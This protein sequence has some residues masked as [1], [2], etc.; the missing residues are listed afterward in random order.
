MEEKKNSMGLCREC[1]SGCTCEGMYSDHWMSHTEHTVVRNILFFML[2]V[3]VFWIGL[4]LGELRAYLK[5]ETNAMYPIHNS[6]MGS[7]WD[8]NEV[9]SMM[10]RNTGP[11][12]ATQSPAPSS[13]R[14]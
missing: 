8:Q 14:R 9:P 4:A 3:F 10:G 11:N 5:Q 13:N 12:T 2:L 6:M 1:K 7:Y